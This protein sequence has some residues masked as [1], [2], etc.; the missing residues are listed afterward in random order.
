MLEFAAA[1]EYEPASNLAGDQAEGVW[2]FLLPSL[3]LEKVVCV[4]VPLA[5]TRRAWEAL[6]A[7][8]VVTTASALTGAV[9]N[10]DLVWIAGGALS[11]V[12]EAPGAVAA[13]DSVLADGGSVYVDSSRRTA[14]AAREL[15]NA[16]AV[17]GVVEV[18]PVPHPRGA[19]ASAPD[20]RYAWLIPHDRRH[21][22]RRFEQALGLLTGG[23]V[24]RVS[25][26]EA[27][28]VSIS[29][30]A[31]GPPEV[32]AEQGLL[33]LGGAASAQLPEYVREAAS[34]SGHDL[35]GARWSVTLPRGYR[36]QKVV[37]HVPDRG[38]IVKVTQD[39]RFN[40]R[41]ENEYEALR[42]LGEIGLR[43]P[44]LAPRALFST[45][46]GALLVVGETRLEGVP[47][48]DRSDGTPA[49]PVARSVLGALTDLASAGRGPAGGQHAAEILATLVR[50][51]ADIHSPP[52][53]HL[54]FLE[55][56]LETLA[57]E[58]SLQPVFLHGD[59]TTFNVLVAGER[60]SLVDW[61][62]AELAGLPLWD[63][64]HFVTAYANWG[65]ERRRR[66]WTPTAAYATLLEPSPF[67]TMLAEAIQRYRAAVGVPAELVG[68][69]LFTWWMVLALREAT[70]LP[71][72]NVA[73]GFYAR[74]LSRAIAAGETPA[75]RN[76]A[77]S[78]AR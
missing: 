67:H 75:L 70:R 56:Q 28:T 40:R 23:R 55:R 48:R 19:I 68:P 62:N 36:S 65:M 42:G 58:T 43:D 13:L 44:S 9:A 5:G 35:D 76:L 31:P 16:L 64:L 72:A 17:S 71:A 45:T 10:C 14:R 66:R 60:I 41:L 4:G 51:H 57:A 33:F 47:F 30:V 46:H 20:G 29:R 18:A 52:A 73:G 24:G 21:R 7:R 38:A 34:G 78:R 59:P 63:V 22:W 37:F 61:E 69:L 54:R 8:V 27:R 25:S 11:A 39:P 26:G 2:L 6:G 74:L 32:G 3:H 49:C 12:S 15:A 50:R 53:A 77:S 1:Q